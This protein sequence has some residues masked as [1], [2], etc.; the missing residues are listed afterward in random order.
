[1]TR[2]ALSGFDDLPRLRLLLHLGLPGD[3]QVV[4]RNV[5]EFDV[6]VGLARMIGDDRNRIHRQ[7]AAAPAIE[8]IDEAMVETRD[9]ERDAL[10]LIGRAHRPGHRECGGDRLEFFAQ[11]L[12]VRMRR[13]GVEHHPHEEV[14]GLRIVE[15][16]GVENVEPAVEQGGRDLRDDPRPVGARQCENMTR[17]RHEHPSSRPAQ[18]PDR[19]RGAAA[20]YGRGSPGRKGEAFKR[21]RYCLTC[22]RISSTEGAILSTITSTPSAFGCKPSGW[23]SFGSPATPSRK[24]G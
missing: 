21:R 19:A 15:L 12:D 9:H 2:S 20:S 16:L 5:A 24:N 4:E 14:A 6:G 3:R 13:G 17:A 1:M 11:S 10:A 7:F 8:E 22:L 23:L 18:R